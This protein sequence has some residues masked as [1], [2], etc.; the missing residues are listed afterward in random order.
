MRHMLSVP[1]DFVRLPDCDWPLPPFCNIPRFKK[2]LHFISASSQP[3]T[4]PRSVYTCR[5]IFETSATEN[6]SVRIVLLQMPANKYFQFDPYHGNVW[7]FMALQQIKMIDLKYIK[8][9]KDKN[10]INLLE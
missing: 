2:I 3:Y 5:F 7:R 9:F 4:L 1:T 8:K 6:Q 10:L